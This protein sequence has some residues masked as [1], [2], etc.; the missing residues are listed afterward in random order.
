MSAL[1]EVACESKEMP[2]VVDTVIFTTVLVA[3]GCP[4]VPGGAHNRK[5][6]ANKPQKD[7]GGMRV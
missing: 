1:G 4:G 2:S 5:P 3:M 6:T 7:K